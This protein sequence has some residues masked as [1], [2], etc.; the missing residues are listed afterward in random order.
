MKCSPPG[1]LTWDLKNPDMKVF[2]KAFVLCQR[3]GIDARSLSNILYWLMELHASGIVTAADTD[4]IPMTWGNPDAIVAMAR[5]VS[6]REGIG[7]LLAQGL[8]AAA[9]HFGRES[10][11][12][13]LMSKGSPSDVHSIPLKTRALGFS[14]SP[15]GA[16]AQTQ[17]VLD[18]AATRRYLTAR[19]EEEYQFLARKY[20]ERAEKEVGIAGAAD[21]RTTSGKAALVRQDEARTAM[22]DVSGVC[23]W[24]S[25]FIGLPVDADT[26]AQFLSMGL[27]KTITA[28]DVAM[29]GLRMHHLERA[30]EAKMGLTRDDDQV[31]EG[32]YHRPK[33][34][35]KDHRQ[36]GITKAELEA[37]KDDYYRIMGLDVKTGMPSREGLEKLCMR[38]VADKLG[39]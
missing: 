3:Y 37:M 26:V 9:K 18:T 15:I 34:T 19:D 13:L 11:R 14:V 20:L 4:G 32:Y 31:S 35:V 28:D 24:M 23:S 25:G 1:D 36:L 10:E 16:D 7:D 6:Y 27:G 39:L 29:A 8:P 17:P 38:D 33:P 12:Y 22:A 21:P 5:K 2:W 30:F